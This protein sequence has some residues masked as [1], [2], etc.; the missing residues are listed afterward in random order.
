MKYNSSGTKQWVKQLEAPS[1]SYEK[2]QGL[3][4]DS[5]DNIYVTGYTNGGLDGNTNSGGHDIFLVKYNSSGTKQWTQQ[6][7]SSENDYGQGVTVDSSDNIYVTGHTLGGLDGN[8]NSGK[9]DIFLVKYNSSGTKQW[10]QQL[11]TP[12]YE[13]AKGVTVDSSDNIYVTGW[14]RGGLDTYSG[15]DDTFLVKYNSSGTKQWTRKFGAPSFLEK[16]QYNSSSQMSSSGDKG[17]GV[18][19]DSSGNIYVTGNTE[20]GMDGNTNSGKNDIFLVK[21]NSM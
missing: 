19:V 16:S 10:T 8:T 18:A 11:G 9:R 2:S 6:F 5:S 1:L 3:A 21:Y 7:G 15:G 17:I 12:T 13:E 20:G 14:T 4:V